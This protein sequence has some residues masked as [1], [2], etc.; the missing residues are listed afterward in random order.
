MNTEEFIKE[1][2]I[3]FKNFCKKTFPLNL[4][5]SDQCEQLTTISVSLFVAFIKQYV[6][7]FDANIDEFISKLSVDYELEIEKIEEE[8]KIK[9]VKYFKFFCEICKGL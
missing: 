8:D 4:K 9:F 1:K 5:I 6:L 3:N 7:P 2:L